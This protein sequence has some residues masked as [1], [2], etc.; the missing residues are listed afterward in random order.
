[1]LSPKRNKRNAFT[2][3]NPLLF[4]FAEGMKKPIF[5]AITLINTILVI[6]LLVWVYQL[7]QPKTVSLADMLNQNAAE[8]A[9]Q[10]PVDYKQVLADAEGDMAKARAI[11]QFPATAETAELIAPLLEEQS[12]EPL[13][14]GWVQLQNTTL[15]KLSETMDDADAL[16]ALTN[17]RMRSEALPIAVRDH[18]LRTAAEWTVK[19]I[20]KEGTDQASLIESLTEM[21]TYAQQEQGTSLPGT[22]LQILSFVKKN[23]PDSISEDQITAAVETVI[24]TNQLSESN[25]LVALEVISQEK[26]RSLAPFARDNLRKPISGDVQ[27]AALFAIAGVGTAEDIALIKGIN[28]DTAFLQRTQLNAIG[29]LE[30]A[31]KSDSTTEEE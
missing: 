10:E 30:E 18:A 3:A 9:E 24:A 19:A 27:V 20:Q 26:L 13:T 4:S 31:I 11:S 22:A 2:L 12:P 15:L 8:P 28:A 14:L 7:N 16:Y 23:A 21:L 25:R 6:V 5:V 1:M 29:K 17:A